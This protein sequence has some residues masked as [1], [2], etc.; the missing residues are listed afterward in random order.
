MILDGKQDESFLVFYEEWFFLFFQLH[1]LLDLLGGFIDDMFLA[2]DSGG[3]LF[4][5]TCTGEVLLHSRDREIAV[6]AEVHF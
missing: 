5:S 2:N 4:S 1:M 6:L 3:V